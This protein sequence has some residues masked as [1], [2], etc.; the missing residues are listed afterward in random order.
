MGLRLLSLNCPTSSSI[1]RLHSLHSLT[2]TTP[3]S[4]SALATCPAVSVAVEVAAVDAAS[5]DCSSL[6]HVADTLSDLQSMQL[7]NAPL[8]PHDTRILHYYTVSSVS[9][10]LLPSPPVS[11]RVLLLVLLLLLL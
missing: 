1:Q 6:L 7:I 8:L 10:R 11:S 4:H 5:L 2:V 9:S 3:P